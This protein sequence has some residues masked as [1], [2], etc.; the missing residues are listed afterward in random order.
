M[1]DFQVDIVSAESEIYSGLCHKLFV[2]G[3]D[4][5]L[6]I[7]HGHAPLLTTLAPGQIWLQDAKG[8]KTGFV[9]LGGI[10]EV[11]PKISIVLADSVIRAEDIDIEAAKQAKLE[12]EKSIQDSQNKSLSYEEAHNK[13]AATLAQIR[14]LNKLR[15]LK[16]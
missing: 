9:I 16:R 5:Q 6:E 2:T 10:L 3:V 14:I 7:R 8:E 11:Q 13:I 12:A 15:K 1:N 4:G